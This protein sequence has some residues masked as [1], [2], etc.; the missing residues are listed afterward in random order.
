MVGMGDFGRKERN[1]LKPGGTA[2]NGGEKGAD[3][4]WETQDCVGWMRPE[5]GQ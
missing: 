4:C 2:G 3:K 5:A 1:A